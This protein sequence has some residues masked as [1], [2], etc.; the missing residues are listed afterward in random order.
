MAR[1]LQLSP[2]VAP[3]DATLSLMLGVVR[4]FRRQGIYKSFDLAARHVPSGFK[5]RGHGISGNRV[6]PLEDLDHKKYSSGDLLIYHHGI[7]CDAEPFIRQFPGS[8]FMVY[9]GLTPASF[10]LPYNLTVAGRLERGRRELQRLA[11]A[12]E[13]AY[14]FSR[15][16]EADLRE[17][18]YL[19]IRKVDP[20][21]QDVWSGSATGSPEGLQP[22]ETRSDRTGHGR[23]DEKP[24][25][26]EGPVILTVGRIVPNKNHEPLIRMMALLRQIHPEARL[27][28]AGELRPGLEHYQRH[29]K[30]LVRTL[31]LQDAVDFTGLV[32][33]DRLEQIWNQCDVYLCSSLHEGYCLPLVEAMVRNRPVVY[34]K[35]A[36][37]AAAET[38]DG[39]GLGLNPLD[40]FVLSELI[41]ELHTNDTLYASIVRTQQER[42]QRLRPEELAQDIVNQM[43][44]VGGVD[45]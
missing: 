17:S 2:G 32:Q 23:D 44:L 13:R 27:I 31:R 14:C 4:I 42:L 21:L 3:F 6:Y 9:H 18:G 19:N 30:D 22:F 5:V 20:P 34:L 26:K 11:S 36:G 24:A 12:F 41:S 35:Y 38:M 8:R 1:L 39:A 33:A 28:L 25:R 37:S 16:T 45:D 15:V 7:A 43:A 29:L 10:Y 40:P